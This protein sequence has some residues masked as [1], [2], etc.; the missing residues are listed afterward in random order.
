MAQTPHVPTKKTRNLVRNLALTG[1][2]QDQIIKIIGINSKT[3][4]NKHYRAELDT[5]S[6]EATA[7]VAGKLYEKCMKGDTA[8][9]IFWMKTRAGWREKTDLNHV[10]E[11]GSM[12]PVTSVHV[13]PVRPKN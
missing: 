13:V 11:D 2:R 8:S 5:G 1:V 4:L 6:D 9:I 7:K 12:T 10:S 3:T